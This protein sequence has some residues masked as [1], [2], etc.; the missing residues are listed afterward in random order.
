MV[1]QQEPEHPTLAELLQSLPAPGWIE[2]LRRQAQEEGRYNPE[3]MQ[4]LLGDPN[5]GVTAGLK[6]RQCQ[7]RFSKLTRSNGG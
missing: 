3:D 5:K 1:S 7:R 4:R 6:R 2:E